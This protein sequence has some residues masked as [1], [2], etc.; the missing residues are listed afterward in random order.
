[1]PVRVA[2]PDVKAILD[3]QVDTTP[4]I[5]T[6]HILVDMTCG[7]AGLS[8]DVLTEMETYWAA[9]L[10]TIRDPRP[11]QKKIG[12]TTLTY[13]EGSLGSGLQSSFYGQ[14]VIQLS[15]GAL[16]AAATETVLKNATFDWE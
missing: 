13:V 15:N 4:F 5:Y 8:E 12:D 16:A 14:V 2:D 3:T 11:H 7:D 10:V 1:M 9:H 6:A